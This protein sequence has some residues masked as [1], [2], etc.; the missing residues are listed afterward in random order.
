MLYTVRHILSCCT[1]PLNLECL[2]IFDLQSRGLIRLEPLVHKY[3]YNEA[4]LKDMGNL[5]DRRYMGMMK[6]SI[7]GL[8]LHI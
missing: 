1:S 4:Q 6:Q 8:W 5:F 2:N 7:I 3:K